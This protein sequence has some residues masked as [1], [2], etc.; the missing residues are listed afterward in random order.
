[1]RNTTIRDRH[2][3]AIARGK[4]PCHICGGEIDYDLPHLDPGAFVVDHVIPVAREGA[5]ELSNKRA[6]HRS[7]NRAKSDRDYAPIIKRSGSLRLPD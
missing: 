5:D 2:R 3:A 6:A 4:P 7:C 1:M